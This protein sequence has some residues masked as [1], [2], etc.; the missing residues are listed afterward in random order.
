MA[1]VKKFELSVLEVN[2][3]KKSLTLQRASLQRSL[4]KEIVGSD[5]YVLRQR[6]IADLDALIN[7]F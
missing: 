2:W 3:V 4:Q 1:D 5:I 7:K 6:E